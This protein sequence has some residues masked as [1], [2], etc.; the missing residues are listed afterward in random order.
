MTTLERDGVKLAY[1]TAGS[2]DRSPFVFVHGWTCNRSYFAPQFDHFA[3]RGH[4]VVAID[5]R[6]HGESDAP[7]GD[8]TIAGFAD[9]VA[10][11]CVQLGVQ[12]PIVVGHSMGSMVAAEL[13]RSFP[14]LP[15]AIVMVDAA[16]MLVTSE[17]QGLLDGVVQQLAGPDHDATRRAFLENM[18]FLPTDDADIKARI[19]A[20][21]TAAPRHVAQSCMEAMNRFDGAAALEALKVPALHI[22]AAQPI[23]DA[24]ALRA[25][26]PLIETAQ[27]VGAGHFNQLVVPD[28]VN[29]MIER[30]TRSM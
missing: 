3:G 17:L 4:R 26:N 16:P 8:Y 7:Q 28:Q 29:A 22:A 21:M 9:D 25:A 13:A 6:G 27:T 19:V 14:H 30:F 18:L 10:W 1:Q 15:K 24:A 5:L 2:G 11:M 20:E 12:Q 23:N